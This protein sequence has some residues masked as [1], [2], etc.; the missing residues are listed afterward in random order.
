MQKDLSFIEVQFPVSK[1][2]KESYKE[3][4]AGQSQT[5]TGLGK[6]WGRKPLILVRSTILGLLMP[7]TDNPLKDREIYL[8]I[9]CMDNKGL[10]ARINKP[11]KDITVIENLTLEEVQKYFEVPQNL[12]SSDIPQNKLLKHALKQNIAILEWKKTLSK[13]EKQEAILRAFDNMGYDQKLEYCLRPEE[14]ELTDKETWNDI[15]QH[16]DTNAANL[17]ELIQQLGFKRFGK[18]PTIGDCFAGGGSIPFEAARMGLPVYASDLNPLAGLLTWSALNILS[19]PVDE[20]KKLKDFQEKVFDKVAEQVEEWQIEKNEDGWLAKYYLY[21]TETVCPECK[22]KVPLAP[23]WWVSKKT[24]TVALL[25]HNAQNNNFDIEII[26]NATQAQIIQAESLITVKNNSLWCPACNKET[27]IAV[28]RHDDVDE[29]K[30]PIYGLRRWEQEEFLPRPDDVFQERLY[31]IKYLEKNERKT[32]EQFLKKPAPATDAT[33]GKIHYIA[34]TYQ[35]LQREHKVINLLKERFSI[36]QEKGYIPSSKIEVGEKTDEPVRTR[37]WQYWHQLFNPQQLLINGLYSEKLDELSINRI[38]KISG[39]IS[40]H[41]IIDYNSKLSIW[42]NTKDHGVNTFSNQSLN[43]VYN[44]LGRGISA[45]Y[46][47]I[48]FDLNCYT[49]KS[50]SE[51]LTK[52]ARAIDNYIQIWITDPPYAD[53]VNYH[54]LSEF[55]L[56]WDKKF[57]AKIFPNWYT[58]SKR[59]LA[60]KGTGESFN[61]S[62]VEIYGNLAK[63]MPE[64]GMQVVMFTHQDPSVWADLTL[65]LWSAGLQVTAAWNIATET[66]GGGLKEGNYVKGTVLLVLRKQTTVKHAFTDEITLEIKEEVKL[67]IDSM[68][69]IDDK[70]DPNFSDNDYLLAAYAASLKV[71]T[72]YKQ[73]DDIDVAYELSKPRDKNSKNPIEKIIVNAI[74]EAYNMLIPNNFDEFIWRTLTPEER[75]YIKGLELEKSGINQINA[76]QE[77]WRGYGVK[78]YKSMLD[79]MKPNH[80]RLKTPEEF[81]ERLYQ[82]TEVFSISLLRTVLLAV[83]RSEQAENPQEGFNFLKT[84][85]ENYWSKRKTIIEFLHYL[86]LNENFDNMEHW[87]NAAKY[88]KQ[89]SMLFKN[90]GV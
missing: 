66:E 59:V 43:P 26:Q 81:A 47:S 19:L 69:T 30:N 9:L 75:F 14:I 18:I 45:L 72:A 57:I 88:S 85:T 67:Q 5:L 17:Q 31:C 82:T 12:F 3:R 16:L 78:E 6:W 15:N 42:N 48:I 60:V 32:W 83:Y 52:D 61:Q 29:N 73:I 77:N 65:I 23:S 28:L 2:S 68:K 87:F 54:E 79:S 90:D 70:E 44:Y 63:N 58:E 4:K 64:N 49:F 51:V 41:R 74:S 50:N 62:M 39:L 71:L 46:T 36:W 20:I 86:S 76:Y 21:C 13:T 33:Y 38:E 84:E 24:N 55:F 11:I 89:M 8:K 25:K 40:I 80:V 7:A 37:G 1:I 35:D 10:H 22:T 53:A 34:P 27:P 56:A